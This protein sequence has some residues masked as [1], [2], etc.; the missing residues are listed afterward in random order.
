MAARG[1]D[2]VLHEPA[3]GLTWSLYGLAEAMNVAMISAL[4]LQVLAA[5]PHQARSAL[6]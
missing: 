5:K 6:R 4:L 3:D 1:L 2:V